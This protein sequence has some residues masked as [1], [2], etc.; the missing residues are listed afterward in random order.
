[1]SEGTSIQIGTNQMLMTI[2]AQKLEIDAL[3]AQNSQLRQRV[4]TLET[5]IQSAIATPAPELL[6]EKRRARRAKTS[7]PAEGV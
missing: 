7:A 6:A 4:E 5:M 3:R 1:M 2:G